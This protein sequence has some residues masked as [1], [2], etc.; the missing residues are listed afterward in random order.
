M[1][2]VIVIVVIVIVVI[3]CRLDLMLKLSDPSIY[4]AGWV[5]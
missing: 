1:V 2:V 4:P 3:V 5:R